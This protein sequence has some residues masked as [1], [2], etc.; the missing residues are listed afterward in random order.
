LLETLEGRVLMSGDPVVSW[1][2]AVLDTLTAL[3]PGGPAAGRPLA[4]VQVAVYDAVNAIAH[5]GHRGYLYNLPAPRVTSVDAAVAQAAHDTLAALYPTRA[6]IYDAKLAED[7]AAVP[8]GPGERFGVALG[9]L[10]AKLVL[11][12]RAGDHSTDVVT[13]TPKT[14][15]GYW[16]PTPPAFAP[17]LFPQWPGV[18]LFALN[19]ADQFRPDPP[20]ALNSPEY[21]AAF[22]EVKTVGALNSETRTAD[23]TQIAKFW[24][25]P[26]GTA[27]QAGHWN[28][29]A[30]S[31][32][33]AR[34]LTVPQEARLFALL[35]MAEMDAGVACWEGKY[36]YNY[37]RPITGINQ[38]D[39][40]GNPDTVADPAWVPLL[41]TPA[42]PSYASGHSTVSSASATVLARFFGTD[43]VSFSSAQQ[44]DPTIVR[45]YTSFTQAAQEAGQ[46]RIYG[47]FHWQF[48]NQAGQ[49]CG[50]LVGDWVFDH[51]LTVG[52]SG[53]SNT[54][55]PPAVDDTGGQPPSLGQAMHDLLT[56]GANSVLGT[57]TSILA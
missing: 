28:R 6:A 51:A 53:R 16:Q 11:D 44:N 33:V 45:S 25:E 4:I 26:G 39:T 8:D 22:N 34:G 46:S 30:Q 13:Y 24:L 14:G 1:N 37:W 55:A 38:A 56:G 19:S 57:S 32:S 36:T 18:K 48:D 27:G 49:K 35:S 9:K 10:T 41:A 5:D 43:N 23:Q 17:A 31:V 50:R 29:I 21:T 15:A 47:G 42:H 54:T 20:P 40:D 7:L 52:H 3:G 2:N 12:N